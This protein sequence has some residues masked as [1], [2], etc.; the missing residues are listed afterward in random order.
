MSTVEPK[1]VVVF[2][3]TNCICHDQ[4]VLKMAETVSS[5]GAEVKIVGRMTRDCSKEEK[6]PFRTHRFRMMF[7]KG[8]LFYMFYNVRLLFYLLF[9]K[10]DIIVA[11]DLDTL[12]PS[13]IVS[14]LRKCSLVYDSHEYF[15]GVPE[16]KDRRTVRAVW[17]TFERIIFPGLRNVITVSDPI[18]ELYF[19]EYKVKPLVI[20]NCSRDSSLVLPYGRDELGLKPDELMLIYQ[21]GGINI[22]RGAEELLAAMKDIGNAVL[23]IIGSGDVFDILVQTAADLKLVEKVRFLPKM[24]WNEMMRY[25]KTADAGFTLDRDTNI[26]YRF[27]LP[28]KLFDYMSA[29]IPVIAGDLPEVSRI[30]TENSCG[31]ILSSVTPD[32]IVQAVKILAGNPALLKVLKQNAREASIELNWNK[33]SE[34]VKEL[35]LNLLHK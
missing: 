15:T 26:N 10:A 24:P 13:R 11:N 35:Y 19:S 1:P 32:E 17:K 7:K 18:S 33:E 28:N 12:L 22:Q 14:G 20:R 16:L 2:A 4:R 3:V 29:G 5:L 31:I 6:L 23:F 34:K 25:T 21:G 27:S 9:R 30:I 8:F